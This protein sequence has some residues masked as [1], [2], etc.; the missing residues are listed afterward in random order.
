MGYAEVFAD[1]PAKN[2][3]AEQAA[4]QVGFDWS[5]RAASQTVV[6]KGSSEM[7]NAV[8][9][10]TDADPADRARRLSR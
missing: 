4:A 9:T 6:L 8:I 2:A 3:A 1:H 5:K 7:K 10:R